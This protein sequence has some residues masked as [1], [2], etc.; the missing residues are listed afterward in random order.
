MKTV[1][2]KMNSNNVVRITNEVVLFSDLKD[3]EDFMP[4]TLW[5]EGCELMGLPLIKE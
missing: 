2:Y 4:L 3:D 5:N 1:I